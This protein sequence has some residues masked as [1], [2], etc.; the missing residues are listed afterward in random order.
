MYSIYSISYNI[1]WLWQL[2]PLDFNLA[3]I[4]RNENF[5]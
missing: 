4:L 5:Y 1:F 2:G 3:V